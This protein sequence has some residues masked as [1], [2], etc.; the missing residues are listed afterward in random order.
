MGVNSEY[1]PDCLDLPPDSS[2]CVHVNLYYRQVKGAPDG[3]TEAV[4][5]RCFNTINEPGQLTGGKGFL[6]GY[7]DRLLLSPKVSEEFKQWF[8][9]DQQRRYHEIVVEGVILH[10]CRQ[11]RK[12]P[13]KRVWGLRIHDCPT[14][15]KLRDIKVESSWERVD[16]NGEA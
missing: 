13:I 9:E 12:Y 14:P 2:Q 16:L 1:F 10:D 4:Y 8:V 7:H 5:D 11:I 15:P 6:C 3:V